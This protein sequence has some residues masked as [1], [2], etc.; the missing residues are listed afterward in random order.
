M[1]ELIKSTAIL[2]GVYTHNDKEFY[3]EMEELKGLA[4]A[5]CIDPVYQLTQ[6]LDHPNNSTYI[7]SGKLI[8][9]QEKV[10]LF[11]ADCV[12]FND[13]LSPAVL[14]NIAEIL[15]CEILDRTMLILEIF[16]TRAK[17]KEACLQVELANL[18]YMLPRLIGAR[19]NLS[20]TGGGGSG[21]TGAR[22]GS[23]ETALEL[24]RRIIENRIS[25]I[26]EE[27][28]EVVKSRYI[29]RSLRKKNNTPSVALAGYTNAG[30]STTINS[31]LKYSKDQIDN[32]EVFVKDMLF[33]TLETST[34]R[35]KLENNHEFLLTDTVGFV[36]KLPHHLIEAFKS[37]LEEVTEASLIIHVIDASSPFVEEQI[38]TTIDVLNKLGCS[39]IPV[40]Y[41]FNKIDLVKNEIFIPT[42]Y[43]PMIKI[44]NQNND[45][46]NELINYID[47]TLF[48]KS[49]SVTLLI[50]YDKGN[51]YNILKEKANVENTEYLE[52]GIKCKV[53]LSEHLYN[54][55]KEYIKEE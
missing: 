2:V 1:D 32:K 11:E 25:H 50:P 48:T 41:C 5:C 49:Y 26:R 6:T 23:G 15:S 54:I 14:N 9:L 35:I 21:G 47:N 7:G 38:K 52:N 27:L 34:R 4:E 55:Y 42:S 17:T 3:Y 20:R 31:L 39:N 53:I 22:R 19:K 10:E 29:T 16:K 45:G 33:A 51:I 28:A 24:D 36:N 8:E 44:S 12:I 46:I 43:S 13:E 37:T 30:K 40:L 18:K